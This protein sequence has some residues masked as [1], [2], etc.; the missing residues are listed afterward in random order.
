MIDMKR[1]IAILAGLLLMNVFA[2]F[3]QEESKSLYPFYIGKDYVVVGVSADTSDKELLEIR[4]NILKYSSIRFTEFDVIRSK[5]G[6]I[7]FLSM[8]VDCRD[9]YN[10]YISHS[11][12]DGD[13][14][15]HGFIRDYTR[16]N[17]DRAFY[18]GDLTSELSGIKR[19]SKAIEDAEETK[20]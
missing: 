1:S 18:Y 9:G 5:S 8:R 10:A 3:A 11:F 20:N 16:T 7:Q 2:L 13:K 6:K 17:Y 15:V 12:E 4:K 14:S 19:V